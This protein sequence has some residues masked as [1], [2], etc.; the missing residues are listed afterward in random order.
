MRK[1]ILFWIFPH[2]TR[3]SFCKGGLENRALGSDGCK[4]IGSAPMAGSSKGKKST[5]W[6]AF[7][8]WKA[9]LWR[10]F[11]NKGGRIKNTRYNA[12]FAWRT[13]STTRISHE[14]QAVQRGF[15]MKN[16][17]YNADFA[18]RTRG[19]TRISHEEH[20]VQRGFRMKN[21]RYNADF[22]YELSV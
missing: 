2:S 12:D 13:R 4:V 19:T 15:R 21:T 14:E 22:A 20:A 18:W 11:G 16:T 1:F 7:C 5:I 9:S 8:V 10:D 17:R 6:A 3:S